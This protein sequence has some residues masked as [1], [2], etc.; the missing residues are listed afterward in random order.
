MKSFPTTDLKQN[1]GDVLAAAGTE[2]VA[3]T[4]HSKTRYILMSVEEY[5]KRM[6]HNSVQQSFAVN[7]LP[8]DVANLLDKALDDALNNE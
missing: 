5:Q 4:R 6:Q 8:T 2:A 3:I 1:I 7:D